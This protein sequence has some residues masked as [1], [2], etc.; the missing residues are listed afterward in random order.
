MY[1]ILILNNQS[2]ANYYYYTFLVSSYLKQKSVIYICFRSTVQPW[3]VCLIRIFSHSICNYTSS[4]VNMNSY[5]A[6]FSNTQFEKGSHFSFNVCYEI[7]VQWKYDDW[8]ILT[9]FMQNWVN[10][11]FYQESKVALT[12]VLVNSPRIFSP[13]TWKSIGDI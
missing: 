5:Y 11:I 7:I 3:K 12:K 6:N 9:W 10:T 1:P 13:L 2:P 4:L 8:F